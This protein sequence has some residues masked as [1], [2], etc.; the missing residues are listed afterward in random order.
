[1]EGITVHQLNDGLVVS[2]YDLPGFK[3]MGKCV[4]RG[5]DGKRSGEV[6]V[7]YVGPYFQTTLEPGEMDKVVKATMRLAQNHAVRKGIGRFASRLNLATSI[8]TNDKQKRKLKGTVSHDQEKEAVA[9]P[10]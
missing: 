5:E 2:L 4:I 3:R 7:Y 8:R 6:D 1:M 10:S 9:T